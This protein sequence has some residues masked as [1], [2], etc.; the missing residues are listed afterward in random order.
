MFLLS[1]L[2]KFLKQEGLSEPNT[3]SY[4][5]ILGVQVPWEFQ[6]GCIDGLDSGTTGYASFMWVKEGVLSKTWKLFKS[7]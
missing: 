5:A 7:D 4:C 3:D 6:G 1:K 2:E